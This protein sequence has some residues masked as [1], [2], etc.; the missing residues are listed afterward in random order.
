LGSLWED[1][2]SIG[3][4]LHKYFTSHKMT[5]SLRFFV[6]KIFNTFNNGY[7]LINIQKY[8][9]GVLQHEEVEKKA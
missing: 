6:K 4:Q 9:K 7:I 1:P 5:V 3:C 2:A 8:Q